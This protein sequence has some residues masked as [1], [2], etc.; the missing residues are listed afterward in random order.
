[1]PQL[2]P[3]MPQL[4]GSVCRSRH[5][6]TQSVSGARQVHVPSSQLAPG[7]QAR[8]QAPQLRGSEPTSMQRAEHI[9]RSVPHMVQTPAVHVPPAPQLF[10]HV[11]QWSR[12]VITSTQRPMH[13][14]VPAGHVQA[15]ITQL[16]PPLQRVLHRPQFALSVI[17]SAHTATTPPLGPAS[18]GGPASTPASPPPPP[19]PPAGPGL[20]QIWFGASQVPMHSP[21]VHI[22][23][24]PHDTPQLPQLFGSALGSRQTPSQTIIGSTHEQDPP[25]HPT[26]AGQTLSQVP[27]L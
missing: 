15:P 12:S 10:A 7:A 16:P 14:R 2:L 26:V 8:A 19:P 1:M 18:P 27:Q 9:R 22:S 25:T 4:A 11:P 5:A 13:G 23:P 6:V 3:H 24:S 20:K 21:A 17:R